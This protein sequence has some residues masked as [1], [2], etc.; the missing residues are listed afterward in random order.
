MAY[1]LAKR[2]NAGLGVESVVGRGS[3][4]T[5]ILPAMNSA[6]LQ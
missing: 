2:L 4:F 3:T 1:E 5:L 6:P